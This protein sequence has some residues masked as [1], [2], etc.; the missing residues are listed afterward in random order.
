MSVRLTRVALAFP[1]HPVPKMNTTKYRLSLILAGSFAIAACSDTKPSAAADALAQDSTLMLEVM[2]ANRD[3]AANALIDDSLSLAATDESPTTEPVMTPAPVP[4]PSR[5]APASKPAPRRTA[6]AQPSSRPAAT[7][8]SRKTT[9]RPTVTRTVSNTPTSRPAVMRSTATIPA[10]TQLA[11][12]SSRRICVNTNNVGDSFTARTTQNL[13]GPLGTVIPRGAT[14]T[15]VVSSLTDSKGKEQIALRISSINVNGRVY[16]IK[17]AITD[18]E[19][20]KRRGA[21]RCLPD[22]GRIIAELTQPL[23]IRL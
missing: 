6:A 23:R 11:L 20:D 4:A 21:E 22:D 8:A 1:C 3:S 5:P 10:G 19:L 7:P 14:A 2:L 17:S 15:A 18:I 16:S 9:P 13:V 12:E